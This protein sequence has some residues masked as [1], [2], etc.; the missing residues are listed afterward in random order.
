MALLWMIL[1]GSSSSLELDFSRGLCNLSNRLQ[2]TPLP[3]LSAFQKLY[4]PFLAFD[5]YQVTH[6]LIK[7]NQHVGNNVMHYSLR[8][9]NYRMDINFFILTST[10]YRW[11]W[12]DGGS[13]GWKANRL[14]R[15]ELH[16]N[17]TRDKLS[18]SLKK[19][20]RERRRENLE[21]SNWE[22]LRDP[23]DSNSPP[24]REEK[25]IS[26]A[27]REKVR[28]EYLSQNELTYPS[29]LASSSKRKSTGK[30]V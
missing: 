20:G 1:D 26:E 11:T 18:P 19:E 14:I 30:S 3:P 6:F 12:K 13:K 25:Q 27:L 17:Y 5:S 9:V 8:H 7:R 28:G 15:N 21:K 10:T 2:L 23:R 22:G 29:Y 16:P 24:R 4:V